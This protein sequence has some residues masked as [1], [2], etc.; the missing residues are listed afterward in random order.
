MTKP[1]KP[2]L[3]KV[4]KVGRPKIKLDYELIKKL[5]TI[6]CTQEE[7]ASVVGVHRSTLLRNKEFCDIY[8]KGQEE[9]KMSLR[10]LQWKAANVGNTTMLVWLGKQYLGQKDKSELS[11]DSNQPLVVKFKDD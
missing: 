2:E 4:K 7:I 1:K 11:G 3:K 5:A 10:R 9:G 8:K 6:Q